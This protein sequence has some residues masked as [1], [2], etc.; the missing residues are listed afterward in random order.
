[1]ELLNY[2][3]DDGGRANYFKG[4]TGDCVCRAI[5]IASGRDYKE[6]YNLL[7]GI[8]ENPRTGVYTKKAKFKRLMESL[9]FSWVSLATIGNNESHHLAVGELPKG[10]LVCS[11]TKHDVAVVNG[12]VRDTWDSRY[13]SW[14]EPRRVYGCW[15][16]NEE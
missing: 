15:I 10:R 7:K 13:N 9:G 2:V 14:G 11:C 5:S 8:G 4:E 3:Y 16:Y 1:M 12:E 6:I